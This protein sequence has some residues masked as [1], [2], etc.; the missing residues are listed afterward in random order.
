MQSFRKKSEKNPNFQN[1]TKKHGKKNLKRNAI[2]Q[3][4]G[5]FVLALIFYFLLIISSILCVNISMV[6][7]CNFPKQILK[8]NEI[9]KSI[10]LKKN[11]KI[12]LKNFQK[13]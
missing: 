13:K 10:F 2:D 4:L 7:N 8:E 5:K 11:K 1:I 3:K 9:Q 12:W 6:N